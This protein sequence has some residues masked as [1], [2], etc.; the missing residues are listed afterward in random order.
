M[1]FAACWQVLTLAALCGPGPHACR[2]NLGPRCCLPCL[3]RQVIVLISILGF[4][5]AT[6]PLLA[7]LMGTEEPA[8]THG[9]H[10]G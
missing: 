6:K 10:G 2:R 5:A 7:Y 1:H 9:Q 8:G 3:C 4:G